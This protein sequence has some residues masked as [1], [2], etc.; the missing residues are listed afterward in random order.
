MSEPEFTEFKNFQ[1]NSGNSE[2]SGQICA[3]GGANQP[4]PV[5]PGGW[6]GGSKWDGEIKW[7]KALLPTL[8]MAKPIKPLK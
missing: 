5:L 7:K 3:S 1:N 6:V 4:S 8:G 2:N